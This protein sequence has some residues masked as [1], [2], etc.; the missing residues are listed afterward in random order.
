MVTTKYEL[1][2]EEISNI[3]ERELPDEE[4]FQDGELSVKE[5]LK[6]L[7]WL[8]ENKRISRITYEY[9]MKEYLI[10]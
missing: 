1:T 3:A 6:N 8:V 10:I 5:A 4:F 9:Y 7:V 2:D